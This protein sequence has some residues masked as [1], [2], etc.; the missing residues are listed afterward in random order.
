MTEKNRHRKEAKHV[1]VMGMDRILY[2]YY[3]STTATSME[4]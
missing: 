4:A 1:I 3:R 2:I